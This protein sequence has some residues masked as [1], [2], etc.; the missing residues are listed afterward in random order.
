MT[1]SLGNGEVP[2]LCLRQAEYMPREYPDM[3]PGSFVVLPLLGRGRYV[4]SINQ[5]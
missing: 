1:I 4:R 5:P 2:L 3:M